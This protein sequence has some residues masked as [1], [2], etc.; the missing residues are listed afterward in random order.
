LKKI[1]LFHVKKIWYLFRGKMF[2]L[3][4]KHHSPH[5]KLNSWSLIPIFAT[6][7]IKYHVV[8]L[9]H[10]VFLCCLMV[11]DKVSCN[12]HTC[13]STKRRLS[14]QTIKSTCGNESG[15]ESMQL[16][17]DMRKGFMKWK[18]S[19]QIGHLSHDIWSKEWQI[20]V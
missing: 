3:G 9:S 6:P 7:W 5:P 1:P 4:G 15:H 8:W 16:W 11:A 18:M 12:N 17:H 14:D 20:S 2:Y 10:R 13:L 19:V